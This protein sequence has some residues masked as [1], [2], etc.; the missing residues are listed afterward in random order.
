M[1]VDALF[2]QHPALIVTLG[3]T[4]KLKHG[5]SIRDWHLRTERT[6]CTARQENFCCLARSKGRF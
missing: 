1:P 3:Q 6:A 5:A 4:E 2:A